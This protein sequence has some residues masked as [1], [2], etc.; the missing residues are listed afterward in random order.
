MVVS[1]GIFLSQLTTEVNH[2]LMMSFCQMLLKYD[3]G[4]FSLGRQFMLRGKKEN[5]FWFSSLGQIVQFDT[6]KCCRTCRTIL[7]TSGVSKN[8]TDEKP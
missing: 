4:P 2:P 7:V 8:N 6:M 5:P 3:R 1:T